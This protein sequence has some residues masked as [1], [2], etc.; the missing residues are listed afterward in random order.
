MNEIIQK[1]TDDIR[2]FIRRNRCRQKAELAAEVLAK[3]IFAEYV[4][5]A[6]DGIEILKEGPVTAS[7]L[8]AAPGQVQCSFAAFNDDRGNT[9]ISMP[10]GWKVVCFDKDTLLLQQPRFLKGDF[11]Q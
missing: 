1:I 11:R 9:F 6:M 7:E 3:H 4:K 5:P 10:A 8:T 2:G